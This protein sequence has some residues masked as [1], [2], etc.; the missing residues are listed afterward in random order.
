MLH[1]N[2]N[3]YRADYRH[4]LSRIEIKQRR[5]TFH[6]RWTDNLMTGLLAI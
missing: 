4:D 5:P 2:P 3:T 1:L 6:I